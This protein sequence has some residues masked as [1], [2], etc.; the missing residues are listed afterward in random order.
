MI[1]FARR[2]TVFS[3]RIEGTLA[4][5]AALYA[6]KAVQLSLFEQGPDVRKVYNSLDVQVSSRGIISILR[7]NFYHRDTE[8]EQNFLIFL[9]VIW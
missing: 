9:R 7:D 2:E 4:S 6:Y 3:S 1:P 8:G 5:L